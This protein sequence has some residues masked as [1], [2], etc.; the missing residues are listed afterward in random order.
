MKIKKLLLILPLLLV[1]AAAGCDND[2]ES[3]AQQNPE[4]GEEEPGPMGACP[5]FTQEEVNEAAAQSNMPG[6]S[7]LQRFGTCLLASEFTSDETATFA[8]DCQ[9]CMFGESSC[10]CTSSG[11]QGMVMNLTAEEFVDCSNIMVNATQVTDSI[12]EITP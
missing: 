1:F 9:D 5:C 2:T 12:C 10:F 6:G 11:G 4:L 8:V 7:L 3:N